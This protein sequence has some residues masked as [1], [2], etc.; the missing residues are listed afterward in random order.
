[1][2]KSIK[3]LSISVIAFI[4]GLTINNAAMSDITSQKVAIVDIPAIVA[5]SSQVSELK[6]EQEMKLAEL[7][8]WINTA[9]ADVEKQKTQEGKE[10]LAKKYDSELVKKREVIR[11]NYAQKL[12]AI[13]KS[14]SATIAEQAKTNGYGLVLSKGVVLY[15]GEDITATI[16]KVLK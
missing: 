9:K 13:D 1:M 6:K 12:A 2:K 11:K 7:Q 16:Q 5:Q 14:I 3:T 15:G 8:K 4:T 10:K